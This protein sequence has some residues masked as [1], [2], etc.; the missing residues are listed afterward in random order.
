MRGKVGVARRNE[1]SVSRRSRGTARMRIKESKKKL[2]KAAEAKVNR[3]SRRNCA[4]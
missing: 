2:G 4:I 1:C 3:R